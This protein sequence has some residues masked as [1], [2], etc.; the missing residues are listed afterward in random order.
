MRFQEIGMRPYELCG[1]LVAACFDEFR[2]TNERSDNCSQ[3]RRRVATSFLPAFLCGRGTFADQES[4]RPYHVGVRIKAGQRV[5]LPEPPRQHDW[6]GDFIKLNSGPVGLAVD[7]EVLI[8]TTV[9]PLGNSEVDQVARPYQV[10]AAQVVV[11][12]IFSPGNTHAGNHRSGIQL[13]LVSQKEVDAAS[14]KT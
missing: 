1:V 5:G 6:E 8:K 14:V 4:A 12:F 2:G 3:G 11:A 13:V 7:P 10:V 9:L